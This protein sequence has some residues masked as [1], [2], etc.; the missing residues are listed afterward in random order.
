[1]HRGIPYQQAGRAALGI[2]LREEEVPAKRALGRR[3][4]GSRRFGQWMGHHLCH[5]KIAS[6]R[7]PAG[8]ENADIICCIR[9]GSLKACIAACMAAGFCKNAL[10]P[11]HDDDDQGNTPSYPVVGLALPCSGDP[12]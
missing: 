12:G 9:A 3:T 10:F 11:K 7:L 6:I 4:P 5:H 2:A 1:M 8:F